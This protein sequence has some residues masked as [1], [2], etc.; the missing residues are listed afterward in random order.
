[1]VR[2]AEVCEDEYIHNGIHADDQGR[3]RVDLVINRPGQYQN[4]RT[5]EHFSTVQ[6]KDPISR[7]LGDGGKNP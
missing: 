5:E 7:R 3:Q 2:E 4:V 1:M 6:D